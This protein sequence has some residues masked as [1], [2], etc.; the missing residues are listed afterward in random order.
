MEGQK[1]FAVTKSESVAS[2]DPKPIVEP[3]LVAESGPKSSSTLESNYELTYEP[4]IEPES[5]ADSKSTDELE[6]G[7]DICDDL[8]KAQNGRC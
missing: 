3:K 6:S 8:S 2:P 4:S 7:V 5:I 1:R